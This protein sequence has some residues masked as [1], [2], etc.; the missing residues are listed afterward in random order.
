MSDYM[1]MLTDTEGQE[2]ERR[3]GERGY[4]SAADDV[5]ALVAADALVEALRD[6]WQDAE[7]DADLL[8]SEFRQTWHD[9][10]TGNT[11]PVNELWDALEN[12]G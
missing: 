12:G 3:A 9:A 7:D 1:V 10:M 2:I 11:R 5:R 8:E 6:D 4:K